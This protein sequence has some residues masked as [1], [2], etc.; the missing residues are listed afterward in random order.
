MGAGGEK[1]QCSGVQARQ[2][3]RG[4]GGGAE[5]FAD[6]AYQRGLEGVRAQWRELE[7]A[8]GEARRT[9]ETGALFDLSES[10]FE[11]A[12]TLTGIAERLSEQNADLTLS[13]RTI[14]LAVAGALLVCF[15]L[16]A[17][18]SMQLL[19]QNRFLKE[20]ATRDPTTSLPN[21]WSCD[22]QIEKYRNMSPLPDLMCFIADLNN[23]KKVNDTLGHAAGDRLIVAFARILA[24]AAAPYGFVGRNGGDEFLGFFEKSA[25]EQL[26]CFHERLLKSVE[27]Y[28]ETNDEFSIRFA[29]G[30]VL[31]SELEDASVYTLIN[32]AEQ[33]MYR[34]KAAA[35]RAESLDPGD[36]KQQQRQGD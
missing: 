22:L 7:A 27:R 12:D 29:F 10:F 24:D 36:P 31:S 15:L 17:C 4:P 33:R 25:P 18:E 2:G 20:K 6:P 30:G 9:G 34:D 1:E 13:L 26:R 28:N 5:R 11:T 23:L 14:L 32:M 3:H 19:Y 16:Q 21:R 8:I 35:K